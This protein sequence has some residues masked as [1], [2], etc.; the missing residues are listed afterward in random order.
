[1]RNVT[2]VR[3]I[4]NLK[5]LP[6]VE[7]EVD[8]CIECGYCE[9]RCPSKDFTITPRQRIVVRRALQRLTADKN[10]T[11]KKILLQQ[12]QFAGLD[13]CAV[14]GLCAT[15]CPVSINTGDLV[16]RLRR[17][18]HSKKANNIA[19][20]VVQYFK[21]LEWILKLGL[22]SGNQI[23]RLLGNNTMYKLTHGFKKIMPS[24]PLW[25]NE[26]TGPIKIPV[27]NVALPAD[28]IYFV[29]C[30]TRVMGADKEN[31]KSLMEVVLT[32]SKKAGYNVV[33]PTDIV[34]NCC[35]QPFSSKGFAAAY[36]HNA[37]NTIEKLWQWSQ[38]G[39][40]PVLMDITSCTQSL[41]TSRPYLTAANQDKFD[42]LKIYDSINFIT[43]VLLPNLKIKT[44]KKQ[45]M[46]H[47]VCT[48]FKMD[49]YNKLKQI[50]EA[51]AIKADIPVQ[52]G[53]CGMAGDRGFYYPGLI[54]A[55]TNDEAAEVNQ[56]QYDGY[57]SS[58]KT[59]E[60]S[61][62]KATSKNYQSLFY[63]LDEVV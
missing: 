35:G 4:K 46:L 12:Y 40:L 16:K 20:F 14:D 28:V 49:L 6:V 57:Y 17:E 36:Q 32:V 42:K 52:A 37:N 8:K 53:C 33:I 54:K 15:D 11:D 25:M 18:N 47:P 45:V 24:F 51:C 55:A 22:N 13:T 10:E 56:Q 41:H 3:H 62:S 60:M 34:G 50:G 38:Q 26:L 58:A 63:L 5:T 1:M 31:K 29:S 21:K 61:L 7:E 27:S 44:P 48:V 43:D 23:N 2:I 19:L 39:R 30:I 59:C 9:N